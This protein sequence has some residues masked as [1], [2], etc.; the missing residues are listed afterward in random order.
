MVLLSETRG[1]IR[2]L[3]LNRP[4]KRNA[5]S[6][7]LVRILLDALHAADAEE[8]V[9][10]VVITGAGPGFCAGADL[11]ERAALIQ[12]E[13]K[14]AERATLSDAL[15]AAP[16]LMGKPVVAALN[17]AVV[18]AGAS[19]ALCCDMAVAAEEARFA[20]PE[21]KHAIYPSLV[22]PML[23]RHLSPRDV[24]ELLATGATLSAGEAHALRLVNRVVPR[25]RLLD[26]AC[27]MAEAAALYPPDMLRR[28]KQEINAGGLPR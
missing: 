7:E 14:R 19:I 18:G 23:L 27:V 10:G 25:A 4:E 15:M 16:G 12:D 3:T 2:L 8:A 20:W 24:F 11:A 13:A 1:R 5:L 26:E 9:A 28:I 22:A 17:G 6:T 21:A